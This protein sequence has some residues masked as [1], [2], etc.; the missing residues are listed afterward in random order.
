VSREITILDVV[1]RTFWLKEKYVI[2][3]ASSTNIVFKGHNEVPDVGRTEGLKLVH[4]I[5]KFFN[6][7]NFHKYFAIL[8]E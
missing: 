8:I 6:L 4:H 1:I 5:V 2:H 7:N 3:G